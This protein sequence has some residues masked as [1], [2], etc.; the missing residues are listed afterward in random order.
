MVTLV[1]R[2]KLLAATGRLVVLAVTGRVTAWYFFA[3]AGSS[4]F[5]FLKEKAYLELLYWGSNDIDFQLDN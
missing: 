1:T 4:V 5:P 2:F 3:V